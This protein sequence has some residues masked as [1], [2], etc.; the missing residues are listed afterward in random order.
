LVA[1][2]NIEMIESLTI[3]LGGIIFL[4]VLWVIVQNLWRNIFSD[5]ITDDD[6][7]AGRSSCSHCTCSGQ[8][9]CEN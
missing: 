5:Q 2:K 7:L 8:G 9:T 4:M 1:V 3:G 6:V